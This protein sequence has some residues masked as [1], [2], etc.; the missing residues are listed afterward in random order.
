[1]SNGQ[2]VCLKTA[3]SHRIGIALSTY[4]VG[5][6]LGLGVGPYL[7]GMLRSHMSFQ[8]MYLAAAILPIAC[9]VVYRLFYRQADAMEDAVEEV[10]E[11]VSAKAKSIVKPLNSADDTV[12]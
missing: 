2:A 9:A 10:V 12:K 8:N 7:F 6:D 4:F 3:D 11:E 1:M 5:L